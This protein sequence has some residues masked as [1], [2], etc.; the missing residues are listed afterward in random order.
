MYK[1]TYAE[2]L[3]PNLMA[4]D[5]E[6]PPVARKAAAG[7]FIILRINETGERIPLTISD[8]DREKGTI[9]LIFQVVGKTTALLAAL[10]GG[11][12]ILDFAGPLGLATEVENWGTVV[13]I[14]GG[15]GTAPIYPQA[16]AFK[17]AGNKIISIVGSRNADSLIYE[18]KMAAVSDELIIATDDGSKGHH[19]FVTQ[20]LQKIIDRGEKIDHVVAIGPLPMM[21]AVCHITKEYNLKTSV[22]LNAIMV[23]GTG[24]CGCCRVTVG[25]KTLFS[26]VD[27]PDFDGLEVDFE[28]LILRQRRFHSEEKLSF[29]LHRRHAC[30]E[31]CQKCRK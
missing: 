25:G 29:D 23:D 15:V 7:Q 30:G 24:M 26:C 2:Q 11:D 5:V 31:G 1:I 17:A 8:Y 18:D 19:G 20:V 4:M 27:G 6:A 22:S 12:T 10:R 21:R 3:A 13:C 9:S 16:R 28:E 14:G